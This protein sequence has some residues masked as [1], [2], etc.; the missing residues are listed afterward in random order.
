MLRSAVVVSGVSSG[1]GGYT[2]AYDSPSG[3][4]FRSANGGSRSGGSRSGYN[5]PLAAGYER[6][7]RGGRGG[8]RPPAGGHDIFAG[9]AACIPKLTWSIITAYQMQRV[10]V[11]T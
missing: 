9:N 6:G 8:G 11:Y 7:G 10:L 2:P 1:G 5:E 4:G 3:G